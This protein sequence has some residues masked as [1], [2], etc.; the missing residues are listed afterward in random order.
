MS[1][2]VMI[3]I[4]ESLAITK[5]QELESELSG[6]AGVISTKFNKPHLLFVD[7]DT[8]HTSSQLL[9]NCITDKGYQAQLVGL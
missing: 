5:Q 9:L 4:N 6:V 2:D 8:S 1:T 7:Y 3:H